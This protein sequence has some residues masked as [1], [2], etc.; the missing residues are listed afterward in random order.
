M[1]SPPQDRWRATQIRHFL[2]SSHFVPSTSPS[3]SAL[4]RLYLHNAP[5]C[6]RLSL[7]YRLLVEPQDSFIPPYL[8]K[9]ENDLS[10]AFSKDQKE[11]I[12]YFAHR[13]SI[14]SRFQEVGFKILT[15]WYRVPT[16]LNKIYLSVPSTC[17]RCQ[18]P[19]GLLL[20]IFWTCPR[21]HPF[22]DAIRRM[23]FRLTNISLA[24]DPAQCLLHLNPMSRCRYKK[25]LLIHLLNAAK[26]CILQ[27]WKCSDPPSI[28]QWIAVVNKI[29]LME[30][31]TAAINH[32]E[33]TFNKTWFYDPLKIMAPL[34]PPR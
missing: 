10:R 6:H 7:M 30:Q 5:L 24:D 25:S 18:Q 26:V 21:V 4:E 17:W 20:H 1:P 31:L 34:R 29:N 33:E 27:K 11:R 22:W 15:R 19:N 3:T 16:L 2:T 9:W 12:L 8:R 28:G 32:K 13:S 23:V 14:A